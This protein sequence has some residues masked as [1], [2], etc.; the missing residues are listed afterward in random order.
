[1]KDCPCKECEDREAEC[2]S[3]CSAYIYWRKELDKENKKRLIK[4][5]TEVYLK[6]PW[7]RNYTDAW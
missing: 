2:H 3:K 4:T 1:M 6:K 7:R 5:S